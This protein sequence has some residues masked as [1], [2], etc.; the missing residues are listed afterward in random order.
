MIVNLS[1]FKS[2]TLQCPL[3]E[4]NG[5]A[6][7]FKKLENNKEW[8]IPWESRYHIPSLKEI[9]IQGLSTADEGLYYCKRGD[10]KEVVDYFPVVIV[11]KY[12]F[13]ALFF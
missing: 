13:L 8:E 4:K 11:G 12:V 5:Y 10:T 7:W 2:I 6:T 3:T 1:K 9:E